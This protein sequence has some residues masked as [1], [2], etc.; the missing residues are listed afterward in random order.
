MYKNINESK[1]KKK[2]FPDEGID[3]NYL[4]IFIRRT[5]NKYTLLNY[6]QSKFA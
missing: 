2:N 3:M 6:K 4:C 5:M 1:L